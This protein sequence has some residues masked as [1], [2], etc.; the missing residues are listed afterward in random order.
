MKGFWVESTQYWDKH[1]YIVAKTIVGRASL[2]WNGG[3][4]YAEIRIIDKH[5]QFQ[6]A[7]G[8]YHS[9]PEAARQEVET[10]WRTHDMSHLLPETTQLSMFDEV[11]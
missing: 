9:T 2:H 5:F 1:E 6:L 11:L 7:G 8:P 10:Y 4:W 3:L